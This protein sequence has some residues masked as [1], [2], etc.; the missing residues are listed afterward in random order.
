MLVTGFLWILVSHFNNL[1]IMI[2]KIENYSTR[3]IFLALSAFFLIFYSIQIP[4]WTSNSD[5]IVYSCRASTDRPILKYAFLDK[6]SLQLR[7]KDPLPNYHLGHTII[8]WLLYH[9]MP[10]SIKHSIWPAGFVSAIS[11][12]F[13]V[14]LTFLLWTQLK[15]RKKTAII[16]SM[17]VGLIPSIWYHNLTGEVYALQLMLIILFIYLFLKNKWVLSSVAFLFANLVSPLSSI[18][19]AFL[20]LSPDIKKNIL[21]FFIVGFMALCAYILIFVIIDPKFIYIFNSFEQHTSGRSFFW[22]IFR[23]GSIIILNFNF[24]L[25]YFFRGVINA[26]GENKKILIKLLFAISPMI[27]LSLISGKFLNEFGSFQQTV[28]WALSFPVGCIISERLKSRAYLIM[29]LCGIILMYYFVWMIPN[30]QTAKDQNRA[31]TWLKS[32]IAEEV[33]IM[34]PWICT[35]NVVVARYNWDFEKISNN[36]INKAKPKTDD[37]KKTGQKSLI[38]VSRKYSKMRILLSKLPIHGFRLKTYNP[39]EAIKT[40]SLK[41]LFET[42]AIAL[43]KWNFEQ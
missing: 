12:A 14:G 34:G 36:Y 21:K 23:L 7:D 30:I 27:I 43:F 15:I 5:V 19:Y 6:R 32:N 42:D 1:L 9:F 22:E 37:I 25:Y 31:G 18:S 16:I 24:L 20:L 26:G 13:M 29:S 10:D 3:K 39:E 8:L 40:G 35:I 28:L 2:S 17:I 11:G 38:I 4:F 33:K 41:I